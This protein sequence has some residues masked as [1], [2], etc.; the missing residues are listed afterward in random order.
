MGL[1]T[2]FVG[3][4][5]ADAR[6]PRWAG[7]PSSACLSLAPGELSAAT[8]LGPRWLQARALSCVFVGSGRIDP[9]GMSTWLGAYGPA[10]WLLLLGLSHSRM[11]RHACSAARF[12]MRCETVF[13]EHSMIALWQLVPQV[14]YVAALAFIATSGPAVIGTANGPRHSNNRWF[15]PLPTVRH[16]LGP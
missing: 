4:L 11:C 1:P 9:I 7:V 6:A 8:C 16:V 3:V 15:V 12:A 10:Y 5:V 2:E 13:L 14:L